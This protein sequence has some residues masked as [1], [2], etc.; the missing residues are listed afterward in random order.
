M[1]SLDKEKLIFHLKSKNTSYV[2]G[3][4][5]EKFLV[6]LYW[7]KRLSFED[8][9]SD[10]FSKDDIQRI[11]EASNKIKKVLKR[12]LTTARA[13]AKLAC[14]AARWVVDW[15]CYRKTVGKQACLRTQ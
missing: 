9:S 1:I 15:G 2:L 3:F 10:L 8:L 13:S 11:Q 6:H 12:R 14:K 7:G 4:L 5:K